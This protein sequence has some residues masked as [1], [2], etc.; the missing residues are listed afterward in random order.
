MTWPEH[1][2]FVRAKRT[3]SK[4]HIADKV[5]VDFWWMACGQGWYVDRLEPS[6]GDAPRQCPACWEA[7]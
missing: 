6:D 2:S 3:N 1:G 5:V 4:V 7:M